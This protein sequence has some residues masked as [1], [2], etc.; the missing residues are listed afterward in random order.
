VLLIVQ[1]NV[2]IAQLDDKEKASFQQLIGALQCG[3]PPHGGIALGMY[4]AVRCFL[5][6]AYSF[7]RI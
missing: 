2:H 6:E 3:A 1:L 4:P 7:D 5:L